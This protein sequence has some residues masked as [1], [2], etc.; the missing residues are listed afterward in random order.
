MRAHSELRNLPPVLREIMTKGRPEYERAIRGIHW[1]DAPIYVVSSARS[2]A[3]GLAAAYAFED[4]LG[5]PVAVRE[6]SAFLAYSLGAIRAGSL[7][8]LISGE[9]PEMLAAAQAAAKRGAQVLAVARASTPIAEMAKQVFS[10]PEVGGAPAA[11]IAEAVLEHV[12]VGYLAL[13]ASRLVKRPQRSLERLESEWNTI[14]EHLD[15]LTSHLVDVVRATA[16]E[17]RPAPLLFFVGDG[18]YHAAAERA[19]GLAQHRGRCPIPGADLARFRCDLLPNL[20]QGAG[21]VF[22]SGSHSRAR[23]AVAELAREA[24]ERGANP[25]AVTGSNDHDLIHQAR[26]TLLL[27]DLVDLPGSILSLALAGWVGCEL[28][29]PPRQSRPPRPGTVA[30]RAQDRSE[31]VG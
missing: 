18:Y 22:L 7:V 6:V 4:L 5:C 28:A 20:S 26:F 31:H 23:K 16:A 30:S 10:L 24:K 17:L 8:V 9:A 27:P 11:G 12:A 19:A 15:S 14:P 1:G 21:V 13:L 3:A 29:A 25:V 2:L